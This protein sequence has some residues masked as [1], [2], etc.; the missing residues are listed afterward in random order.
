M[1]EQTRRAIET[2]ALC[3]CEMDSLCSMFSTVSK[4]DIEDIYNTLKEENDNQT[5]D[6][7]NDADMRISCNCS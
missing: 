2:M 6:L 7:D 3:G 1:D 5:G 4:E